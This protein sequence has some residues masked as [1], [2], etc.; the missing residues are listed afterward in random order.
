MVLQHIIGNSVLDAFDREFVSQSARDEDQR[1]VRTNVADDFQRV[2]RRPA[3]HAIVRKH[4]VNRLVVQL[5]LEFVSRGD[6]IDR[7]GQTG[8]LKSTDAQFHVVW[9]V[10]GEKNAPSA[11]GSGVCHA[12]LVRKSLHFASAPGAPNASAAGLLLSKSQY[13]PNWRTTS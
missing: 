13:M 6:H 3:S 10:V 2:H 11:I 5:V 12:A 7:N 4:E 9:I 8:P 1:H